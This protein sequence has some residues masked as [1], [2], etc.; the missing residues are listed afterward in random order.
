MA[1]KT[2]KYNKTERT[3]YCDFGSSGV[4]YSVHV[5]AEFWSVTVTI[6]VV[7]SHEQQ[8][9]DHL[10]QEGLKTHLHDRLHKTAS[11]QHS[12]VKTFQDIH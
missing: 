7:L 5:L 10:M 2:D 12:C 11:K 8:R 1:N 9:M 3:V 4:I 6:S